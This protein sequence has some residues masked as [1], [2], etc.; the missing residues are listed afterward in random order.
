M[1]RLLLPLF[2]TLLLTAPL[3]AE[4]APPQPQPA[5]GGDA[6]KEQQRNAEDP[7]RAI[8]KKA[9]QDPDVVKLKAAQEEAQKAYKAKLEAVMMLDPAYA[10]AKAKRDEQRAKNGQKPPKD[11]GGAPSPSQQQ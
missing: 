6:A 5:G 8:R 4:D 7:L 3:L 11:G 2:S 9:E 1:R 10:E